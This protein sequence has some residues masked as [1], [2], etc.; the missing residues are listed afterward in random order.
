MRLWRSLATN[1]NFFCHGLIN[2]LI[3]KIE[4]KKLRFGMYKC[5]Q[6]DVARDGCSSEGMRGTQNVIFVSNISASTNS[7]ALDLPKTSYL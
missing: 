2:C 3:Q 1:E 5:L 4:N 6:N 7:L